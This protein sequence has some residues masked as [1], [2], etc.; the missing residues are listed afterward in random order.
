MTTS[1]LR[2]LPGVVFESRAPVNDE[3]LPRMDVPVFAGFAASG[4]VNTPVPVEDAGQFAA[5]FGIDAPL[6]WDVERGAAVY[7]QLAPAVRLFFANGGRRCW[8]IRLASAPE[9]C[10]LPVPGV[11]AFAGEEPIAP[12]ALAARSPGS[13]A[14]GVSLGASMTTQRLGVRAFDAEGRTLIVKSR[15]RGVVAVG[16]LLRLSWP[17]E[18]LELYLGVAG[19][20]GDVVSWTQARWFTRGA[21]AA[22]DGPAVLSTREVTI[23]YALGGSPPGSVLSDDGTTL[24]VISDMAPIAGEVIVARAA[25]RTLV[26][27]IE[28]IVAFAVGPTAGARMFTVRGRALWDA[29][30]SRAQASPPVSLGVPSA[31]RLGLDV[32]SRQGASDAHRLAD[33]GLAPGHPR[34]IGLLPSDAL[35]YG[36]RDWGGAVDWADAVVPRFPA[37]GSGTALLVIPVGVHALP[38]HFIG[39]RSS[40]ADSLV[41]DGLHSFN[42]LLFV[43]KEVAPS[44]A[45]TLLADAEYVRFL[46]PVSR[47]QLSGIHSALAIEEATI[48]SVPD[49][50]QAGWVEMEPA[51]PLPPEPVLPSP[52]DPCRK[53]DFVRCESDTS[54][55]VVA[56][57]NDADVVPA[58]SA[59]WRMRT[60]R[61]YRPD[62]LLVV[63]RLATRFCAARRDV[64]GVLSLPE[65]YREDDAVAHARLLRSG[66]APSVDIAPD[67]A[68]GP[69]KQGELGPLGFVALYH[70]WMYARDERG[71]VRAVAPDGAACGVIA[72]RAN[73]RG[74]WVA[75]ANEPLRGVLALR[76]AAEPSRWQELQQLQINVVRQLPRG[77]SVM[78]AD[79]L[80]AEADDDVRPINVRRLLMLLRRVATRRGADYVFEPN[81][82]SFRRLVQRGFEAVLGDMF[83]RGAFAGN[84]A[85]Q[86]FQVV[87]ADSLNTAQSTDG[88]RF[89]VELRVAPA[90]PLAFLTIRL[91]QVGERVTVTGA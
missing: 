27:A 85:A 83:C 64:L 41:R 45:T 29:G 73:A 8:I 34:N 87:T 72:Q 19:V 7:A 32:W 37:A 53:G 17:S 76:H 48:I 86:A 55:V 40:D 4:P 26:F 69:L 52:V 11:V 71:A 16:D 51:P 14:D 12:L 18:G 82:D 56:P 84:T 79:T 2:R 31:E 78:N 6:A 90:R 65:H 60:A 20:T 36:A 30:T 49:A 68:I 35:V 89:I 75:P 3:V 42:P 80:A 67:V 10:R 70:G 9:T 66:T 44:L 74:A 54:P 5:V 77:F 91:V 15:Q 39:A 1:A 50:A 13:W 81:D 43:D 28:E 63:H 22:I 57:A 21:G 23:H 58:P 33:L 61:E 62:V 88:G 24:D 47:E 25:G 38:A 46:A 59:R